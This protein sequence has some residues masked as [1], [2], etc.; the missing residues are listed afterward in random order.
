MQRARE[1][2]AWVQIS[3]G[4]NCRCSYCIVPEHARARGQPAAR[5]ARRRGRAARRRRR[6]RGDAA[7]PERQLLRPRPARRRATHR[8]PSCS[9]ALDAVDGHRPDPLHEPAPQGHARGRRARARRAAR[10]SASTS[11][12]RCSRARRRILKAMRR[13]YDRER[14]L[15]RVALIRE[16]V[17]DCAITTDI[18][19]GFPGETEDGLRADAR[20]RRGGRLRRRVHV[21]LLAAARHRGGDAH[22]RPRAARGARSSAWSGSSRSSSAARRERAQRFVGRTLDVLV[23]GPS[24]TDPSRLRGRTRHNKVVELRGP[25]RSPA[26]SSRSRSPRATSQTL[27][28]E[29]SLLARALA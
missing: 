3:V 8:S 28:G 25:R 19:V 12:C 27:A 26:R 20:G 13:T 2:Q 23:E 15:D 4:C 14:Y 11:T 18:I 5:R 22:R 29:M 7:R 6:A 9:R 17:P 10:A 24:R 16:H 1:F 21:R